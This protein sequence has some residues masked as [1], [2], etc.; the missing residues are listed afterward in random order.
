M[1]TVR[2]AESLVLCALC[3]FARGKSKPPKIKTGGF[4]WGKKI[5][6]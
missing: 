2:K 5:S 3:A 1:N 4:E 6:F